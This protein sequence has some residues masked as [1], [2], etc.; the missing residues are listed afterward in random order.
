MSNY[1]K[2]P[3]FLSGAHTNNKVL[4]HVFESNLPQI[5]VAFFNSLKKFNKSLVS[6]E[7]GAFVLILIDLVFF[8][9]FQHKG[10]IKTCEFL[11]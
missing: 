3:S 1:C 2:I 5:N 6:M 10:C 7:K 4:T 8:Y 11:A 9:I